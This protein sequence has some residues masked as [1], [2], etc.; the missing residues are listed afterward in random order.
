MKTVWLGVLAM[1]ALPIRGLAAQSLDTAAV[2]ASARPEIDRANQEW[3]SGFVHRDAEQIAGAYADS[4]LFVAPDGKV[5]RGKGAIQQLYVS[6]LL[7]LKPVRNGGV[8]HDGMAVVSADRVY[9]W[10][11]AWL[12]IESGGAGGAPTRIGGGYLTVWQRQPDGH[13]RIV[14]NLAL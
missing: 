1:L 14:R 8:V 7:D 2:L 13:W 6:R 10:G 3:V 9:E 11:H 5:T 4:G 12:E